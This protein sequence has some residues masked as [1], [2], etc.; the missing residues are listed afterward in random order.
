MTAEE[1]RKSFIEP[2]TR[3]IAGKKTNRPADVVISLLLAE[4]AAQLA[5]LNKALRGGDY[6]IAVRNVEP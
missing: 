4:I 3:D 1:I 2:N 6:E 5:E